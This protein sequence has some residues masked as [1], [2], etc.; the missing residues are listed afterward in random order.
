MQLLYLAAVAAALTGAAPPPQEPSLTAEEIIANGK[1]KTRAVTER[2][3]PVGD[4]GEIVVC[5]DRDA[6]TRYR[7]AE[8]YRE[9]RTTIKGGVPDAPNVFGIGP[10]SGFCQGFG[11]VPE[12]ILPYT[13][14]QLPVVDQEYLE[15]ARQA[16]ADER[17]R[18][19]RE[20]QLE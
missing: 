17:K 19:A 11:S 8:N 18:Q 5:A 20:A 15:L 3:N 14:D 9:L 4:S 16:E 6:D 2:C 12:P 1:A 13:A 10:C 7:Q